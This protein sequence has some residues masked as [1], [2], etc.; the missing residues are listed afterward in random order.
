MLHDRGAV[1]VWLFGSLATA[2]VHPGSDVDLAVLG[3]PATSY[4]TALA[5]LM[6]LFGTPVD[7]VRIEEAPT[8]LRE[9]IAREGRLL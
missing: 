6:E 1:E 9:R 3:L 5:D 2:H 4:F 7:L 8:S